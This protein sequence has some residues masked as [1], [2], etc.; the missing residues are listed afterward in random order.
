MGEQ[1][2]LKIKVI[3]EDLPGTPLPGSPSGAGV[4]HRDLHLGIQR[5]DDIIALAR[6][7]QKRVVFEPS[8]R[9][10]PLPEDKTN[11]LGPFAKGTPTQRFFY[12]SWAVMSEEGELTMIGRAKVHLSHLRWS[13]IEESLRSGKPLTVKLSLTDQRGRPRCGSIKGEDV[14]W[15]G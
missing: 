8:F 12:L 13:E 6:A 15:H 1:L 11:F 9:V 3:C 4:A 5:G 14:S 10:L 7:N 2:E